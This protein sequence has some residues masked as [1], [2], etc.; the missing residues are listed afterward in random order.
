MEREVESEDFPDLSEQLRPVIYAFIFY[1]ASAKL[2]PR[3]V[4]AAGRL[5][6]VEIEAEF[7]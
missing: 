4:R 5:F 6:G 7:K 1:Y 3:L 2:A